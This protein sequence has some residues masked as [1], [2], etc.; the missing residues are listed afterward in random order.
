MDDK[1]LRKIN[2]KELL[3][4]LL[5]QAKRIEELEQ[6]L[7]TTQ[8]KLDSKKITI[9][10]SGSLAEASL[11]LNGIFEMAQVTAEQYLFNVKEK[12]RKIENN[13][14]KECQVK[15]EQMIKETEEKC[16]QKEALAEEQLKKIELKIKESNKII[17]KN[18]VN[19]R[20]EN[21]EKIKKLNIPSEL[22]NSKVGVVNKKTVDTEK[23]VIGK[24][25]VGKSKKVIKGRP[26]PT[27]KKGT[28]SV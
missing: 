9:E 1:K 12:C 18:T 22:E 21:N 8:R 4:I 20:T 24:V 7:E 23:K 19:S 3:E 2:K 11:K 26:I 25:L 14:K 28:I 16:Q 17:K 6:Q 15:A 13:M 5:S 10:N 27:I